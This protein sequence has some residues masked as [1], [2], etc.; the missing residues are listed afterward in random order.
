MGRGR[1]RVGNDT[2]GEIERT[3]S[4]RQWVSYINRQVQ[5]S[6]GIHD[7][8]EV[9]PVASSHKVQIGPG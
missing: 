9:Y 5:Y 2:V 6:K 1:V 8:R 7:F 4:C 3:E